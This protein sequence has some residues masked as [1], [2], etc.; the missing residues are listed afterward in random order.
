MDTRDKLERMKE[1]DLE[2][3][4]YDKDDIKDNIIPILAKNTST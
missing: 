3:H 4:G 2:K 1:Q